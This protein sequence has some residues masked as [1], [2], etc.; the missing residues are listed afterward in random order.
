VYKIE[1]KEFGFKLIF[2]D[3]IEAAEMKAWVEESKI[4]LQTARSPFGIMV[5]MR[6]LKP[7]PVETQPLMEEGQ[8]LYK[9]K[10]M[11]RSAVI[12]NELITKMQFQRL[13]KKT[14]IYQWERY[15]DASSEPNWEKKAL[16][17]INKEIDPDK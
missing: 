9:A 10:G 17:W 5:D 3:F 15:F 14:G 2:G 16:D 8:K 6:T 1:K 13:A 12:L 7:L 11:A 4:K